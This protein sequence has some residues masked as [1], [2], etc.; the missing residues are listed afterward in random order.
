MTLMIVSILKIKPVRH[1]FNLPSPQPIDPKFAPPKK[2]FV[3][4][5]KDGKLCMHL[6]LLLYSR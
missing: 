1:Y 3:Q 5:V 4:S 6:Y 2:G